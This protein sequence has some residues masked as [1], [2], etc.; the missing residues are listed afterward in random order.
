MYKIGNTSGL[1]DCKTDEGKSTIKVVGDIVDKL[2]KKCEDVPKKMLAPSKVIEITNGC[3]SSAQVVEV[4]DEFSGSSCSGNSPAE[5][6]ACKAAKDA[7][8]TSGSCGGG[9]SSTTPKKSCCGGGSTGGC[10]G[11]GTST[12]Q[13][14]GQKLSKIKK[15][16]KR[17]HIR[18][19]KDKAAQAA[20][21]ALK[22]KQEYCDKMPYPECK[23]CP[24]RTQ[25]VE[26]EDQDTSALFEQMDA[27]IEALM[28]GNYELANAMFQCPGQMKSIIHTD[29]SDVA[30]VAK[31]N[32]IAEIMNLTAV[33][34]A[35]P[36]YKGIATAAKFTDF[37][38][39]VMRTAGKLMQSGSMVGRPGEFVRQLSAILTEI[40]CSANTLTRI[41]TASGSARSSSFGDGYNLW[42]TRGYGTTTTQIPYR[43]ASRLVASPEN[44]EKADKT[45][46]KIQRILN[47]D[48]L[49]DVKAA[50]DVKPYLPTNDRQIRPDKQ[51][52]RLV[53][54]EFIPVNLP[55]GQPMD[56]T[57]ANNGYIYEVA[58]GTSWIGDP[59]EEDLVREPKI[60]EG[61]SYTVQDP[62]TGKFD[63]IRPRPGTDVDD[64]KSELAEKYQTTDDK[65]KLYEFP[66]PIA[67]VQISDE[68]GRI[69]SYKL[70]TDSVAKEGVT[71]YTVDDTGAFVVYACEPGD[72]LPFGLYVRADP[73]PGTEFDARVLR[74]N[75]PYLLENGLVIT[76]PVFTDAASQTIAVDTR[77]L[78]TKTGVL[79]SDMVKIA[80]LGL[81]VYEVKMA[82]LLDHERNDSVLPYD[83]K[84]S[85]LETALDAIADNG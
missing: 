39:E 82:Y 75:R 24:Y 44:K 57:V 3:F 22:F 62:S 51:Y 66:K 79:A 40:G 34:G 27:A 18:G 56:I 63:R 72:G 81:S 80:G 21:E 76:A 45:I 7:A 83:V 8:K 17:E 10:C 52:Y 69:T 61:R 32:T 73:T 2:A 49:A 36:A 28:E 53:N 23:T 26:T 1:E 42:G 84:G 13:Q 4:C 25:Q 74:T 43:S 48:E 78:V 70:N 38:R 46:Q 67:S 71:Y 55:I 16:R 12:N 31:N 47:V 35:L 50:T 58:A 14:T 64:L 54:G 5:E 59:S 19:L 30:K 33:R 37:R 60:I 15:P 9:K 77:S 11:G 65:I 20:D 41:T 29:V 85:K 6:E 68:T